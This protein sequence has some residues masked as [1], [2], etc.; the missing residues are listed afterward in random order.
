MTLS[1]I[2]GPWTATEVQ[3]ENLV[4]C[5]VATWPDTLKYLVANNQSGLRR[6]AILTESINKM[7][8]VIKIK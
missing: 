7:I 6:P 4:W 1:T 2:I 3:I 8:R 5:G